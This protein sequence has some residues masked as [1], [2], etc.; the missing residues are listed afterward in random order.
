MTLW[1]VF[2]LFG[3]VMILLVEALTAGYVGRLSHIQE[4]ST[5]QIS[6]PMV[7]IVLQIAEVVSEVFRVG[8]GCFLEIRLMNSYHPWACGIHTV[9]MKLIIQ[10]IP[11]GG[12]EKDKCIMRL[13]F[14]FNCFGSNV[15]VFLYLSN[16][17]YDFG[18]VVYIHIIYVY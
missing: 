9:N 18:Q 14:C 12:I 8:L 15:F 4:K 3:P 17:L 10:R 7:A 2:F 16:I 11:S 1:S 5:Y 6:M 13:R